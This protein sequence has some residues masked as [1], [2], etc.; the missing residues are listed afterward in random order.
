MWSRLAEVKTE[1]QNGEERGF[2]GLWTWNSCWCQ[3]GW[4]EYLKNFHAQPSLWFTENGP[5][6][7]KY[8]VSG[9]YV[10]KKAFLMSE[11]MGRLV[12]DDRKTTLTQITSRFNQGIQN[13]ISEH[14]THRTLKQMDYSSRRPHRVPLRS[15]KNRKRRIQ[16]TLAHQNWTI[17]DWKNVVWS[18]ESRFLL[19]HSDGRVRILPCLNGSDK[20]WWCNGV[21]NIFLAH[22]GP[23]SSNWSS[24]KR[25]TLPEYYCWPCPSL[26]DYNVPFFWCYFQQD[27]EPSQSFLMETRTFSSLYRFSIGLTSGDWLGHSRTLMCFFLSHSFVALV[28]CFG[29]LSCWKLHPRPIFSVLAEGRRFSSNILWYLAPSIGPSMR[30]S[31]PVPLAEKQLQNM[32]FPPPCLTVG[33]VFL[34]W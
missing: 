4:S 3:T 14:T 12:R 9:S 25:H 24:F 2:K 19:R 21:G 16:F 13:T 30:R 29:S 8:P 28:V 31:H 18:D 26:Y 1:H 33:M 15:T 34:G 11:R 32:M 27:N 22:F 6:K 20:L 10:D 17:E 23:L 5:K 7:R